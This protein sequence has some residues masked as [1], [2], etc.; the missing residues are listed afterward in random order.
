V[1]VTVRVGYRC[2]GLMGSF[3]G[4]SCGS[5]LGTVVMDNGIMLGQSHAG[6]EVKGACFDF[7]AGWIMD[8]GVRRCLGWGYNRVFT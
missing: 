6:A 4:E 3:W 7:L 8:I 5:G 1:A 2:Y